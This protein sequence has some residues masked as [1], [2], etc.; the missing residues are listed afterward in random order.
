V[1]RYTTLLL[2]A[3]FSVLFLSI[4]GCEKKAKEKNPFKQ[5]Q[6]TDTNTT[7]TLTLEALKTSKKSSEENL[8]NPCS[9]D[10]NTFCFSDIKDLNYTISVKNRQL[11]FN[12]I[13]ETIV[14]FNFFT[15]WSL[16]CKA[17]V[18]YLSDLQKKY[19]DKLFVFGILLNP[20]EYRDGLGNFIQE[21]HADYYI[22]GGSGN[23]SFAKKIFQQLH[24]SDI[25]PVPLTVIYHNGLYYRHYEAAVPI[26]MVEHDIK[27]LIRQQA[28]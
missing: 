2:F 3:I 10:E 11:F 17:Q 8:S 5:V 27:T 6:Q 26:E 28:D 14:V 22:S 24:L 9:N 23:N 1:R 4:L 7:E 21:S 20:Q 19:R 25:I 15:P 13:P 18:S 12:D 16:L